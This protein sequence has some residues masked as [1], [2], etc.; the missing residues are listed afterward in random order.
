[1]ELKILAAHVLGSY[2]WVILPH[3]SLNT[4]QIPTNRP[5]DGLRVRFRQL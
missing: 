3:Q 5:Q 2:D 1:M 4:V